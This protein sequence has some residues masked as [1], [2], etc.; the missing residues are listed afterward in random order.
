MIM[1]KESHISLVIIII[2]TVHSYMYYDNIVVFLIFKF[3]YIG[4]YIV[5]NLRHE[6]GTIQFSK[7]LLATLYS[8]EK[9]HRDFLLAIGPNKRD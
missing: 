4:I 5:S 6:N 3:L 7:W 9:A 1:F 8:D 2:I